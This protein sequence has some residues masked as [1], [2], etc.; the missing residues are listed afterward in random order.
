VGKFE[1]WVQHTEIHLVFVFRF[2]DPIFFGDYPEVM[3]TWLG[4][5]LPKFTKEESLLVKGS[6]DFVGINHY[7]TLF[8]TDQPVGDD[9]F[10]GAYFVDPKILP[11]CKRSLSTLVDIL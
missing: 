7:T 10:H 6:V 3:R 9:A 8:V 5:R 1:I 4:D 2:L 11:V